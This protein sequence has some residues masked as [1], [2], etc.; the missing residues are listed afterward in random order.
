MGSQHLAGKAADIRVFGMSARELYAHAVA[1]NVF[2]AFGVDDERS[3]IHVDVRDTLAR[4]CYRQGHE[5]PW[6][7]AGLAVQSSV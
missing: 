3:F 4:W 1:M 7:E 5:V 2:R 6:H